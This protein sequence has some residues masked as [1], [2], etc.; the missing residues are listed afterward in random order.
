MHIERGRP[1][2]CDHNS[3]K[4]SLGSLPRDALE[5]KVPQRRPQQRLDGRLEEVVKAVGGGYCRLQ[6]PL[7][8]ALAVSGTSAG[9]RLGGLEGGDR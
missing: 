5:G 1:D 6:I 3:E 8:L 7:K 2:S 9:Q 4:V